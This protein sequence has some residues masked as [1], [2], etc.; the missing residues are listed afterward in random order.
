VTLEALHAI[1]QGLNYTYEWQTTDGCILTG[2]DTKVVTIACGGTYEV[3]IT[4]SG[5]GQVGPLSVETT[6]S[7]LIFEANNIELEITNSAVSCLADGTAEAIVTGG[8]A[9]YTY[10]WSHGPITAMVTDLAPG[11]YAVTVSDD[12]GCQA[13]S[14]IEIASS[15]DL[16]TSSTFSDCDVATGTA[17]ATILGGATDPS[18]LWSNGQVGPTAV[19][20]AADFYSVTVTDNV[21]GCQTHENVQVLED[22]AC[23]VNISGNVVVDENLDCIRDPSSISLQN[24]RIELSDGQIDFTDVNGQYSFI[25][26]PGTYE[27]SVSNYPIDVS[28]LCDSILTID[29][30]TLGENYEDNDFYFEYNPP[31][32]L[33]LKVVKFNARPG[34]QQQVRICLMNIGGV[35]ASGTLEMNFPTMIDYLSANP[36]V[37]NYDTTGFQLSWDF[38]DIPPGAVWVYTPTFYIPSDLPIGTALD[39]EFEATATSGADIDLSNNYIFCPFQVTGAYDP[40]DKTPTPI[41][42]GPEGIIDAADIDM[43]YTIRFQNTGNDTAF[44][45]LLRDTLSAEFDLRTFTP[46]PA[47]HDYSAKIVQGNILEILFEN[48]LLPDSFVNEPASNGFFIFD[49][50]LKP[51][52]VPGTVIENTAGIYFD[53]NAP[54]ITNTT[55]NTIR[56]PVGVSNVLKPF[57][58]N[59]R[60]NPTSDQTF[61]EFELEDPDQLTIGLYDLVG[62]TLKVINQKENFSAGKHLIKTDLTDL[63][64][65]VYFLR[66]ESGSGKLGTQKIVK[67]K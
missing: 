37:T 15:I 18:F 26:E 32:D 40:N 41:G 30:T 12:T 59:L 31:I 54:I 64:D 34:F 9:P 52:L 7:I 25:A 45:V 4:T 58:F 51:D 60:P 67:L 42:E 23:S 66:I 13:V 10:E 1:V 46:G 36:A 16:E 14:S 61:L 43:S 44:T 5:M 50:E 28:L 63:S 39:Y 49:I 47:S 53:F 55:I 2:N 56:E 24:F 8:S 21:N 17:T 22:P 65:G 11:I 6:S 62:K 38:A 35:A 20:L 48:I 57:E 33:Q 27:I 29:A 3:T 19:D